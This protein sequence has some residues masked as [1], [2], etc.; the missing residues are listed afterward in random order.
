[1]NLAA[2]ICLLFNFNLMNLR[3]KYHDISYT[4][5][6]HMIPYYETVSVS[7]VPEFAHLI[8]LEDFLN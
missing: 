2:E 8:D 1:M 6:W 7:C 3:N 4:V 5:F